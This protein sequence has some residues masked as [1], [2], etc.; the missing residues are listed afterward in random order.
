MIFRPTGRTIVVD[1]R[2]RVLL[3]PLTD[4]GATV[5][6]TPGG[7]VETSEAPVDAARRELREEVGLDVPTERLRPVAVASGPFTLRGHDLWAEDT[8]FLVEVESL[9]VD[10]SGMSGLERQVLGAPRWWSLD[11]LDRTDEV[12]FPV[13]LADLI[14]RVTSGAVPEQP[15]RLPWR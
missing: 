14:R 11:E 4:D 15:L 8:F 5:W 12:V 7:G 10:S 6:L 2:R 3:F 1:A 9:T 13:G